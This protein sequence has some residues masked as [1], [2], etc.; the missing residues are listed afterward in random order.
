MFS[1]VM[2]A[3]DGQQHILHYDPRSSSLTWADGTPVSMEHLNVAYQERKWA[4]A[5]RTSPANPPGKVAQVRQVKIQLGMKCNFTCTYCNQASQPHEQHGNPKDVPEFMTRLEAALDI[6]DGANTRFEFWGGEPFV[7]WKTLKP[8]AEAVRE[9][10]PA[11]TFNM[12]SNGSLVDAEKVEWLDRLG[13][14]IGI[15]HDGPRARNQSRA[16]PVRRPRVGRWPEAAVRSPRAA[17]PHELQLRAHDQQHVPGC[18]AWV[19]CS[20]P[21]C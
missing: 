12:I 17:G 14:N 11:A 18:G 5:H 9:R 10:W 19:R 8:L 16:G 3:G 6:G 1:L 20:P 13:F 4:D 21:G 15:S 7:Y 2:Q